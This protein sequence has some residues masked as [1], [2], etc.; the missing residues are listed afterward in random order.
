M[1]RH[2]PRTT[3]DE[4][5]LYVRTYF[6]LLRSSG[7]VRVRAFE[8]AH[9]SSSS[10]LHEGCRAPEPDVAAFAY[11][12]GR[13]PS[14]IF[15]VHRIVLG[16]SH[17]HFEAAGLPV[18][19]WQAVTTR[20]RRRPLRYDGGQTLAAFVTSI[21]D[22]DDLIPIVTAFQIE[23]NKMHV[24]LS[25]S[26]LGKQLVQQPVADAESPA[27][28]LAALGTALSLDAG[29]VKT[30]QAAL[31]ESLLSG[32]R[33]IAQRELELSVRLLVGSYSQYQRAA[34][35]WWSGI[36]PQYL[37]PSHPR[38]P[39][40]YFVSSNSHSVVNL[41]GGYARLHRDQLIQFAQKRNPEQLAESLSEAIQRGNQAKADNLL[42]YLLRSFLHDPF[43]A[44]HRESVRDFDGESGI[45]SVESPGRIDVSAQLV[46]IGSL[47]QDRVDPRLLPPDIARS[48]SL[49]SRSDAVIVNIDYPLG[50][51]AYHLLSRLAQGVGE[52]RGI[53]VMGKAATLNGRVGDVMVSSVVHDEHSLNTYLF[54]NCFASD[55]VQPYLE[56]GTVLDNQ[57]ALTVRSAFLQNRAYMG[58]FYHEGYTVLEMEA[59][60]YL[61]A[62]YEIVNPSRHPKNEIVHLSN[63]TPFE[64]G[65]LHY[66][67]DTPYSRRQS[68]LSKSL[69]YFGVESTYGCA[70]AILSRILRSE[71]ARLSGA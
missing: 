51:A 1:D 41:L 59:G 23:W 65:L 50:M 11:S 67:S 19:E 46:Q 40:V 60:P 18:R 14:C 10:S 44:A 68:L 56:H 61:S 25:R 6:S 71:I 31:G 42:Y 9:I 57:K 48:F 53:Y 38:R 29:G 15:S 3:S 49:L 24:L 27:I 8:E 43:G 16:Q 70:I 20:G 26:P 37:R 52:L 39:P 33:E 4:I 54:R 66:A 5:D 13:L 34:Q 64:V 22:I 21:S 55:A 45:Q 58:S 35:R 7:E 32:L 62:I 69:S 28:D 36:E 17:E 63:S 2:P 12:A 30:L 47:K